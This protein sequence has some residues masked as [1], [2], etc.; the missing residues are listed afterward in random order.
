VTPFAEP[1]V[2]RAASV[3]LEHV[4]LGQDDVP[5]LLCVAFAALD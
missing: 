1:L 2:E 3:E 4:P 5:D